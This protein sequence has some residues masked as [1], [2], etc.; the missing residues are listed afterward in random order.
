MPANT[1]VV[2]R[3]VASRCDLCATRSWDGL[4]ALF[5]KYEYTLVK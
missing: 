1:Y 2:V 3:V 5:V 4:A